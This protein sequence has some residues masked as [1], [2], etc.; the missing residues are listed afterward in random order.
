MKLKYIN[1]DLEV[2]DSF[3]DTEASQLKNIVEDIKRDISKEEVALSMIGFFKFS[4]KK[5]KKQD[6]GALKDILGKD[7]VILK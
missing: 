7:N 3:N 5:D 4:E 1:C 2:F 6:I